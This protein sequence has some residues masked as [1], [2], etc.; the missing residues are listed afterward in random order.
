MGRKTKGLH[1]FNFALHQGVV[2]AS[3][4]ED[5]FTLGYRRFT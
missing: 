4:L 1:C 5:K 3:K 2:E